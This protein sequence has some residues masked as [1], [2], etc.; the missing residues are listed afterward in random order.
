M[1]GVCPRLHSNFSVS[2]V[3]GVYKRT[4]AHT[5]QGRSYGW[6]GGGAWGARAP[7]HTK[8]IML[9]FRNLRISRVNILRL[10]KNHAYVFLK[11]ASKYAYLTVFLPL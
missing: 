2:M 10:H 8:K 3:K 5:H 4:H 11:Y 6:G 9:I 7:P 1:V